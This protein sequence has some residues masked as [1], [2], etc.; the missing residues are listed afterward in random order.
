MDHKCCLSEEKKFYNL[1]VLTE[2]LIGQHE[3]KNICKASST[4]R[5]F[6]NI[7]LFTQIVFVPNAIALRH[8][9]YSLG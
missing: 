4:S 2:M 5:V 1:I 7:K 6:T 3:L 8:A 9:F